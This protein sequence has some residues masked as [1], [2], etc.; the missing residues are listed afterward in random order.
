MPE[1]TKPGLYLGHHEHRGQEQDGRVHV[2]R[3]CPRSL[4]NRRLF[5]RSEELDLYRG[6][7]WRVE[8]RAIQVRISAS[9]TCNEPAIRRA[10]YQ[11]Y[12]KLDWAT[13]AR[14]IDGT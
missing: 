11:A 9:L 1:S 8:A 5:R 6:R 4:W 13:L 14:L 3:G 12:K 10:F 7:R 2:C